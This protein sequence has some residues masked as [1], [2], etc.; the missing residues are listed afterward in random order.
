MLRAQVKFKSNFSRIIFSI[1]PSLRGNWLLAS[2]LFR[3]LPNKASI[4]L[5]NNNTSIQIP[6]KLSQ[7]SQFSQ[8]KTLKLDLGTATVIND[9]LRNGDT[10]IDV[11]AN[12]GY[13]SWVA[14]VKN[15]SVIAIEPDDRE[16]A[17]LEKIPNVQV[18]N[19]AVD[20]EENKTI[21]FSKP[22][23]HQHLNA[24][25]KFALR[26]HKVLTTTI[27]SMRKLT[28]KPFSLIKIDTDGMDFAVLRGSVKTIETDKP[29]VI[30]EVSEE[31]VTKQFGYKPSDIYD[32]MFKYGYRYAYC[33]NDDAGQEKII[34]VPNGQFLIKNIL[35]T[36]IPYTA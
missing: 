12:W 28:N 3:F 5:I 23:I 26:H 34:P 32:F 35:F 16:C 22:L 29:N 31:S 4:T 8:L 27:D 20:M 30:V 2:P 17:L 33:I 24:D 1:I 7:P 18:F 21:S 14:S 11:G 10:F 6:I 15:C 9:L 36:H 25:G 19:K 13:F